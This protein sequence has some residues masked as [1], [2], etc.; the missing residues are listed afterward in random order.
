MI[1][2]RDFF[3]TDQTK[4]KLKAANPSIFFNKPSKHETLNYKTYKDLEIH[5]DKLVEKTEKMKSYD[6]KNL[7]FVPYFKLDESFLETFLLPF[8]S[9]LEK[10]AL[11]QSQDNQSVL[12]LETLKLLKFGSEDEFFLN[13][14]LDELRAPKSA[15]EKLLRLITFHKMLDTK[16]LDIKIICIKTLFSIHLINSI[17]QNII[18]LKKSI[19]KNSQISSDLQ[20]KDLLMLRLLTKSQPLAQLRGIYLEIE[21]TLNLTDL[22]FAEEDLKIKQKD[23]KLLRDYLASDKLTQI[24][25]TEENKYE[26]ISHLK[27]DQ[28]KLNHLE[29]ELS[30]N[31]L[32]IETTDNLNHANKLYEKNLHLRFEI[33]KHK[34]LLLD[35][36]KTFLLTKAKKYH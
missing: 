27:A 22:F 24:F 14:M 17:H 3:S 2:P 5:F 35:S 1:N 21:G 36:E 7:N 26:L 34:E 15:I 9:E 11:N 13:L 20:L 16:H 18:S 30:L 6:L 31:E 33:L 25:L 19:S 32:L 10:R 23:S 12:V 4:H 29:S 28:D 8:L